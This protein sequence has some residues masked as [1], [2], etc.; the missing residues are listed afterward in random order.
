MSDN[1][2]NPFEFDPGYDDK[3]QF[4]MWSTEQRKEILNRL[5]EMGP[6]PTLIDAAEFLASITPV[7]IQ[8]GAFGKIAENAHA[9][10]EVIS[11]IYS[12]MVASILRN[13]LM[14]D[15]ITQAVTNAH[16]DTKAVPDEVKRMM[17]QTGQHAMA[18]DLSAIPL[19]DDPPGLDIK[20]FIKRK[21]KTQGGTLPN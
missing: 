15:L 17:H 13:G 20:D 5:M 19:D 16:G 18:V 7:L 10:E 9:P 2:K 8:A 21:P 11:R 4:H 1:K 3:G 6:L 12:V 14:Q